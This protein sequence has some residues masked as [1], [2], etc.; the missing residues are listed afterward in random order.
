MN[1]YF[2]HWKRK[3]C[4]P[5]L[6]GILGVRFFKHAEKI[7]YKAWTFEL[8]YPKGG[9]L[10]FTV[11]TNHKEYFKFWKGDWDCQADWQLFGGRSS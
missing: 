2:K 7:K 3:Q 6:E 9:M 4:D 5:E 1:F 11:T 10:N 8:I